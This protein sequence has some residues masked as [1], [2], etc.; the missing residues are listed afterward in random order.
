MS[1]VSLYQKKV[2][3]LIIWGNLS[4]ST[5]IMCMRDCYGIACAKRENNQTPLVVIDKLYEIENYTFQ[6]CEPSC[7]NSDIYTEPL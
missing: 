7:N 6:K 4:G 5:S 1:Y 2:M 3:E